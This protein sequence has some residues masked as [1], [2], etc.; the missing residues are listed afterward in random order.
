MEEAMTEPRV[1]NIRDFCLIHAMFSSSFWLSKQHQVVLCCLALA[2][3]TG[4]DKGWLQDLAERGE[5]LLQDFGSLKPLQSVQPPQSCPQMPA[6]GCNWDT[7]S[8]SKAGPK[9]HSIFSFCWEKIDQGMKK[10]H[11]SSLVLFS[12]PL[13]SKVNWKRGTGLMNF[14]LFSHKDLYLWLRTNIDQSNGSPNPAHFIKVNHTLMAG[15]L[16]NK[17]WFTTVLKWSLFY[18]GH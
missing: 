10:K 14:D 17:F 7:S 8:C 6:C 11:F 13:Y 5:H 16:Q 1:D 4:K 18:A 3:D 2:L 9:A 15:Q 12:L